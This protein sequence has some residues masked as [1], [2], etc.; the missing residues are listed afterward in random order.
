MPKDAGVGTRYEDSCV[1]IAMSLATA[2]NRQFQVLQHL[3]V[4][5]DRM[6]GGGEV[7]ADH[8]TACPGHEIHDWRSRRLVP[9]AAHEIFTVGRMKR[10]SETVFRHSSGEIRIRPLQPGSGMGLRKLSGTESTWNSRRVSASSI[11]LVPA[12]RPSRDPAATD[13]QPG[14]LGDPYRINILLVVMG[15][16]DLGKKGACGFEIVVIGF[17]PRN[18]E[19][20]RGLLSIIPVSMTRNG[21]FRP[22]PADGPDD[23][24]QLLLPRDAGAARNDT[25]AR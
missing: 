25:I 8:G 3:P 15:T 22:D 4:L 5:L 20:N 17:H 23:A 1:V 14:L 6:A 7:I 19:S 13:F 18:L 24:F 16:A 9:P 2:G 21:R 10:N 12:I 11:L